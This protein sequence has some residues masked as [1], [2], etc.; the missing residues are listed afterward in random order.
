KIIHIQANQPIKPSQALACDQTGEPS[1]ADE[2]PNDGA[3]LLLDPR[4]VVLLVG[5]RA[6]QFNL[7]SLAMGPKK[8]IDERAIIVRIDSPDRYRQLMSNDLE[9]FDDQGLLPGHQR[10][11]LGPARRDIGRHQAPQESPLQGIAAVGHEVHLQETRPRLAPIREGPDGD[12]TAGL[13]YPLSL[14]TSPCCAADRRQEPV[15]G[16][17]TD[18]EEEL[19]DGRVERQMAVPF[20]RRD[21]GGQDRF[22]PFPT[23]AIRGFPEDDERFADR[24]GIDL[25]GGPACIVADRLNSREQSNGVF[26]MAACDCNEYI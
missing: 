5:P 15:N 7:L 25:A 6:R 20:H 4:L 13:G 8:L 2:P 19:T 12:L 16:R 10:D 24:F 17:R 11:R 26:T 23:D 9:S 18:R 21:Q 22:E 1:I 14:P 3:V